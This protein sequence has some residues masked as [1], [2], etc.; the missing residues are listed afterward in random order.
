M[1]S[2]IARNWEGKDIGVRIKCTNEERTQLTH[3]GCW[4]WWRLMARNNRLPPSRRHRPGE[5]VGRNLG[6]WIISI[7]RLILWWRE[8]QWSL[9]PFMWCQRMG[10]G[11]AIIF[12]SVGRGVVWKKLSHRFFSDHIKLLWAGETEDICV[13]GGTGRMQGRHNYSGNSCSLQVPGRRVWSGVTWVH[14]SQYQV[15]SKVIPKSSFFFNHFNKLLNN[16]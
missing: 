14:S 15:R 2:W 8:C 9:K 3:P 12:G 16:V 5:G 13:P 10:H 4:C 11:K 1:V 7:F 6:N